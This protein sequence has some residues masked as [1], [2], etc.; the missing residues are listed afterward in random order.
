[1]KTEHNI[2]ATARSRFDEMLLNCRRG[3]SQLVKR[4]RCIVT[5]SRCGRL[6][7]LAWWRISALFANEESGTYNCDADTETSSRAGIF[8]HWEEWK[9]SRLRKIRTRRSQWFHLFEAISYNLDSDA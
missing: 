5:G 6:C 7:L 8:F 3:M 2:A 4:S 1:M 9:L